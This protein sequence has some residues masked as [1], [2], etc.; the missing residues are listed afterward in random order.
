[1]EHSYALINSERDKRSH[2]LYSVYLYKESFTKLSGSLENFWKSWGNAH[3][4][5]LRLTLFFGCM[6]TKIR[7]TQYKLHMQP[8]LRFLCPQHI[9]TLGQ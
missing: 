6:T 7:S 2:I 3:Q 9:T 4:K 1:M 5:S 8:F